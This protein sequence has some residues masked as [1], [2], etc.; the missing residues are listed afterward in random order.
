MLDDVTSVTLSTAIS[1]IAQQQRV[2][3]DNLS[4]L[5]T[6]GYQAQRLSFEDS[7]RNAVEAGHP[8]SATVSTTSSGDPSGVN[9]NNVSLNEEMVIAQKSNTQFQLLT[10]AIT[11]KF[12]L[13][14]TVIKG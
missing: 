2:T 14:G 5:E 7:L 9:G 1:A 6:P 3:A 12:N 10:T 11:A 4:N 8:A 13:I